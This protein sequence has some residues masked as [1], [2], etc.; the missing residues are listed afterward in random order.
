MAICMP[1]SCSERDESIQEEK[2]KITVKLMPLSEAY[3][4]NSINTSVFRTNSI[5]SDGKFQF[6]SYFDADGYV[7]F[8]RRWIS[9]SEW[10]I[11]RTDF[12]CNCTDAHNGIS[13]ALDGNG[14][15]HLA[16]DQHGNR[17]TYRKSLKPYSIEFGELQYMVNSDEEQFVTYPEFYRKSNGNLIFVYRNGQSGNGDCVMNEYDLSTQKW[18]RTQSKLLDGEGQR[19]AYWQICM[20]KKD[21]IYVS[22]VWRENRYVESNH[23]MCYAVSMNSGMDWFNSADGVYNTPINIGKAEIAWN[24][25]QN[26]DLINQ[27][28]M[29]TDIAGNPYIAT[30]WR[31]KDSNIPQYRILYNDGISWRQSQVS[32]RETPF[33]LSG[34]GTKRIPVARPRLVIDDNGKGMFLFRDVER[35]EVVSMYFCKD[36][37]S[38][39]WEVMDLTDFSVEAWEPTIDI[40]RWKRDNI[41][42][43]YVQKS[44]QGDGEVAVESAKA[45]MAYV[46]EI[47]WL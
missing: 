16:Y 15:I 21:N 1:V 23:D 4:K 2:Y 29:T 35:N 38:Q 13:I 7:T 26:S 45:E 43:V 32:D 46:L 11:I 20:D 12:K 47:S 27:T 34:A 19:N 6:V 41:L 3:A 10:E 33:S 8:A 31:S 9:S 30:Y 37:K 44:Y 40:D 18:T 36:I 22:W 25:P 39:K 42:D 28:S 24:I 14:Y 17:L 5:C